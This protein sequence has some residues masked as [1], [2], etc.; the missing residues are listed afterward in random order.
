MRPSYCSC[1]RDSGIY[2]LLL[3]FF[4]VTAP[5][6][7]GAQTY[8]IL[9][10][11]NSITEGKTANPGYRYPL[12]ERLTD[13]YINFQ[14]IG[15]M[16]ETWEWSSD[17]SSCIEEPLAFPTLYHEGH[18][19][20]RADQL[21]NGKPNDDPGYLSLWLQNYTPDIVL[22]HVGTND[23]FQG[24]SVSSTLDEIRE[25]VRILRVDKPNVIILLAKL[26]PAHTPTV[27]PKADRIPLLNAEIPALVQ[28]L[29]TAQSP[30]VLVDQNTGFNPAPGEDTF[31]GIHTN[32]RG[33]IKMAEK[34]FQALNSIV[35]PYTKP[36][37][38]NI[39]A[40]AN[41]TEHPLG[42]PVKISAAA[43]D[44]EG[45][46]EMVEFF[47]NCT[48]IGE[49]ASSPY[50]IN[51]S[52][53]QTG[54]YSLEARVTDAAGAKGF[55]LPV[56]VKISAATNTDVTTDKPV[57]HQPMQNASSNNSIVVDFSLPEAAK[58][59]TVKF[60]FTRTDGLADPRAP[61]VLTFTSAFETAGRH[62]LTLAG[63]DLSAHSSVAS[64][65]S[66]PEDALIS[67]TTYSVTISYQDVA[68]NAAASDTQTGFTFDTT[69][70]APPS[71]PSLAD[72]S[73]T[74]ASNSDGNRVGST[75]DKC[76]IRA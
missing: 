24:E 4:M 5:L 59:G 18:G 76:I 31:D 61:H 15:S 38:V 46:V 48:K 6:F 55:S 66:S 9:P 19:G 42:Q 11:G 16:T 36:P 21:L 25:I 12:Y 52:P 65:S 53:A 41:N 70:P 74:G 44:P 72:A 32:R 10:I 67:G 69:P 40:P 62:T 39:S 29:N 7:L 49:D 68:G 43:S 71:K 34:W 47:A 17:V 22:L 75:A 26:I 33:A 28:E 27:G 51:W 30:V 35:T 20:W 1:F 23:M 56:N 58:T 3:T 60:T 8:K 54:D 63:N 73:D 50:E 2:S 45:A 14:F 64:V 13:A 57:L 37:T